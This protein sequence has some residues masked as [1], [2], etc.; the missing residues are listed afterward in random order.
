MV[1]RLPET[2]GKNPLYEVYPALQNEIALLSIINFSGPLL[3]AK[4]RNEG[5]SY[6]LH[7]ITTSSIMQCTW[8]E[9]N[10]QSFQ[11]EVWLVGG[12]RRT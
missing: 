6:L 1:R 12:Q 3:G 5:E 8:W 4:Q 7:E 10:F 9:E 11:F 2:E